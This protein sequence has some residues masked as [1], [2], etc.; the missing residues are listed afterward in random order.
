MTSPSGELLDGLIITLF[1]VSLNLREVG[2][3]AVSLGSTIITPS[4]GL[5]SLVSCVSLLFEN[6]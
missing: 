2:Y 4:D 5:D 6:Q 1:L 3:F